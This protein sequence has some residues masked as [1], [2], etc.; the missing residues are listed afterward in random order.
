M[1]NAQNW[2][3][4][5][6][7]ARIHSVETSEVV[8]KENIPQKIVALSSHLSMVLQVVSKN[9]SKAGSSHVAMKKN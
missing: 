1:M 6:H 8:E 2:S 7:D 3:D 9:K 4:N 5:D